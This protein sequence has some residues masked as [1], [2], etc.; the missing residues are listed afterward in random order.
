MISNSNSLSINE[1]PIQVLPSLA[2]ALGNVE[3]ATI[4]QQLQYLISGSE[5]G[6]VG[7]DGRK[8]I[9]NTY[10]E[11]LMQF[12]WMKLSTLRRRIK[13]LKD[14]KM[15]L[16]A[17]LS[18]NNYDGANWYSINYDALNKLMQMNMKASYLEG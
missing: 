3:E 16:T 14:K 11:W 4:L 2:K 5:N 7:D 1:N 18:K 13:S 6:R 8:Y 9:R 12:P 17:N 15:I 10:Q